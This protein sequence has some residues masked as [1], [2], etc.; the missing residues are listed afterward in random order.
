MIYLDN[1]ATT[2]PTSAVGRAVAQAFEEDYFNPSS[3]YGPA[4][5]VEKKLNA[6]RDKI[7]GALNAADAAVIF[8]SGGTEANNLALTG[9]VGVSRPPVRIAVSAV[10]HPSLFD[11]AQ[12]LAAEGKCE[13]VVLP[14]TG[15]G[16]VDPEALKAELSKGLTLLSVMQVNNETG[17][18]NDL[19]EISRLAR[20]LCPECRIHVDGV[21]GFLREKMDFSLA[22]MYTLSGHKIHGPKGVGA[23]VVRKG[24]RLKPAHT[25]GGQEN[26]LR[27]GTENT[28]GIL[29]LSAAIDE[30]TAMTQRRENM[31][32][33]K[34]TLAEEILR[35]VPEAVINGPKPEEGACHILNVSFTGVRGETM[36]HALEEKGVLVSTGSACSSKKRHISRVLSEMGI[37]PDTAESAVRFS[38]CPYTT[39]EEAVEAARAAAECH[40]L[41]K[42]FKRR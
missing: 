6:C 41:L 15:A 1:S 5:G 10:E 13:T 22:D 28:P 20:S 17:A 23:L 34:L 16:T 29:G 25:G 19:A 40:E 27:S 33:V 39:R 32:R 42:R 9:T 14:V 37:N 26:A 35:L 11:T 8:T 12:Q 18:M 31:L 3:L 2:R 38:L 36:L 4:L 21:Q 30:M 24:I 7:R